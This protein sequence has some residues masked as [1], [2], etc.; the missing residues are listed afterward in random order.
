MKSSLL[1]IILALVIVVLAFLIYRSINTPVK[2]KSE[3]SARGDVVID[4]LKDI[5]TAEQLYKHLNKRYTASFDTLVQFIRSGKIPVV[6]IIPDPKDTTFTRTINDTIGFV[7]IFDSIYAKKAYKIEELNLVPYSNGEKFNLLAGQ[8]DKGGVKVSV[9]EASAPLEFYSKGLNNQLVINLK[10]EMED[11]NKFPG[12]K[13]GSML[14]A[15]TD[16]NWE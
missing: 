16:G 8:I 13:V 9:F 14:D 5:R 4:K 7:S 11:K 1:K 15:S 6:K 3:L 12:L 10:K 2:F